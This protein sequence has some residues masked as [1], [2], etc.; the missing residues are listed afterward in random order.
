MK[1]QSKPMHPTQRLSTSRM[2]LRM[3]ALL[4]LMSCEIEKVEYVTSGKFPC[5]KYVGTWSGYLITVS[6]GRGEYRLKTKMGVRGTVPV[7]LECNEHGK[8]VV[9][10]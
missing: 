2:G 5:G 1:A 7:T 8:I 9:H 3:S 4:G 6:L 10:Q